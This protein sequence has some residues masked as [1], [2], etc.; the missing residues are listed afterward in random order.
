MFGISPSRYEILPGLLLGFH[1]TD[2]ETAEKVL[3]GEAHLEPSANEYDWLGHGIYFWEYSPQR[4]LDFVTE[5][6]ISPKIT[7]G[8]IKTPA[9]V[10]AVIDPGLC[11][12]MLEASALAQIKTAYDVLTLIHEGELPANTGGDD[13]RARF[14]DCAVVETLHSMREASRRADNGLGLPDY[15]TVRG[16]F[17]EGQPLYPNAGFKEKNH[18]QICVRNP[19]CIKGYFRVLQD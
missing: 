18:V 19:D 10:G 4:A 7:K 13:L 9:V 17:W 8:S 1:G 3:A 15:D 11:L 2:E 14:L 16:A 12:N 6:L 5:S